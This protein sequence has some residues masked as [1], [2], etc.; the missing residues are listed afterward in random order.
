MFP[1]DKN[2]CLDRC[3]ESENASTTSQVWDRKTAGEALGVM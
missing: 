2:E 1:K 3:L